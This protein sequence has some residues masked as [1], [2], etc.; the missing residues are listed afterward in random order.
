MPMAPTMTRTIT[1]E[2]S[3]PQISQPTEEDK[4]KAAIISHVAQI[5]NSLANIAINSKDR[6]NVSMQVGNV[7]GNVI[8]IAMVASQ[9]NGKPIDLQSAEQYLNGLDEQTKVKIAALITNEMTKS[10]RDKGIR[11]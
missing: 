1:T 9:R 10:M 3:K 5:A 11:I 7:L 2:P 4:R 6:S 8:G